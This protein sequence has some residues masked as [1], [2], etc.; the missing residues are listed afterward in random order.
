M[1]PD[2]DEPGKLILPGEEEMHGSH[3]ISTIPSE[4]FEHIGSDMLNTNTADPF[5]ETEGATVST[6]TQQVGNRAA[7]SATTTSLPRNQTR[8][9]LKTSLSHLPVLLIGLVI[10]WYGSGHYKGLCPS[11]PPTWTSVVSPENLWPTWRSDIQSRA[12][13]A[14]QTL[15][16]AAQVA[17]DTLR[18]DRS[19]ILKKKMI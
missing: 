18:D 15:A 10:G 6:Q 14:A 8:K 5:P 12:S 9:I 11:P 1:V 3:S 16:Q 17:Q 4:I 19:R 2:N 7:S 13:A